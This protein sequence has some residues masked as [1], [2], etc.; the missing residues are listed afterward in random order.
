[1]GS[2]G[3]DASVGEGRP[4]LRCKVLV[5][6]KGLLLYLKKRTKGLLPDR[7]W[8]GLGWPASNQQ[9]QAAMRHE[10]ADMDATATT[11]S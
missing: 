10:A 4:K 3:R 2:L 8:I 9:V 5:P 7:Y 1:M 6:T 11:E